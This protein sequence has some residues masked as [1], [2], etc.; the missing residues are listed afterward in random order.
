MFPHADP[1]GMNEHIWGNV[2]VLDEVVRYALV[3]AIAVAAWFGLTNLGAD[4]A[5]LIIVASG[6]G[7]AYLLLSSAAHV[8]AVYSFLGID[9][10]HRR[11]RAK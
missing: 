7:I 6:F 3:V 4:W 10:R 2:G 1:P 8:D 5:L 9:T 11:P